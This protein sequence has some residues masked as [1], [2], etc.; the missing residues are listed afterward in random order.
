MKGGPDAP[1]W[2]IHRN[3]GAGFEVVP[4]IWNVPTFSEYDW[5]FYK[6]HERSGNNRW[7]TLDLNG[8]GRMDLAH[9]R[10][11]ET[12]QAFGTTTGSPYWKVYLGE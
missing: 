11:L 12:G 6:V 7:N 1:F 8:D 9:A 5:G 10:D 3:D 4:T 2:E